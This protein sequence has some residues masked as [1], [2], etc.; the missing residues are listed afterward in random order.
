MNARTLLVA[1][2]LGSAVFFAGAGSAEAHYDRYDR[3]DRNCARKIS[4]EE[5]RLWRDIRRHGPY[6]RQVQRRRAALAKLYRQCG[7]RGYGVGRSDP[8]RGRWPRGAI[9][10][11]GVILLP[12]GGAVVLPPAARRSERGRW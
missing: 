4:R 8:R 1:A 12:N 2:A 10:R 7:Y 3:F 11:D 5:D 6:S 9:R